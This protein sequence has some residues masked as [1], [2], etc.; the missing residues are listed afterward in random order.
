MRK[1]VTCLFNVIR[2]RVNREV[3]KFI[4]WATSYRTH[5]I[6]FLTTSDPW[7]YRVW[8]VTLHTCGRQGHGIF[9]KFI[10][11]AEKMSAMRLTQSC[12][13]LRSQMMLKAFKDQALLEN[14][15]IIVM[16]MRPLLERFV[17]L[18]YNKQI[19][20]LDVHKRNHCGNCN[21]LNQ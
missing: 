1:T 19:G 12:A 15:P 7:N 10:K 6:E 18:Q 9:E 8:N 17:S 2:G 5:P 11:K 20:Q 14:W 16:P 13:C 4:L 3:L 21:A